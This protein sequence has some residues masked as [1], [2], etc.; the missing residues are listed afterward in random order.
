MDRLHAMELFVRVVETGSFSAAARD[1]RVGQPAVSKMVAALE[2]RLA[3]RLL[4]R[5]S[6]QLSPTE[7]GQAFYERARRV[8]AEAEEAEHAARGAGA[9]LEGR[10]RVCVPV[11]FGRLYVAARVGPF[12]EAHP[13][14]HLELVMDDRTVDL[15]AENI[16]VAL[17]LGDL[18][19]STLT[20]RK[21]A[22]ASRVLVATPA[23]IERHGAPQSPGD[24]LT[25][26]TLVYAQGVD[27]ETWRFRRGS[28]ET[29]VRVTSRFACTAAEGVREGV[30]CGLGLAM[31]S[32]WM[33]PELTTG[34][35]VPLLQDWALPALDLWAVF[36]TGRLPSAKTRAFTEWFR[37]TL[38][39]VAATTDDPSQSPEKAL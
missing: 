25:H 38:S 24:L 10:L 8:I 15:L 4:A 5:S 26:Q 9:G 7:A 35:V 30:L 28:S 1:L 18:P 39:S 12:L 23:Y 19:D 11:T 27:G 32:T 20:A 29:S 13:K 17:R 33:M 2:N 6:R 14:L 36:P 22:T 21:L 34:E 37:Q 3:V 31:V 16:D